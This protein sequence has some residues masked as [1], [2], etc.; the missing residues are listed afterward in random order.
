MTLSNVDYPS[1]FPCVQ[2]DSFSLT[3]GFGIMRSVEGRSAIPK[4]QR[5]E[6]DLPV[7]GDLSFNVP[8]NQLFAWMHWMNDNGFRWFNIEMAHPF[9]PAGT[10]VAKTPVRLIS[11]QMRL[12]YVQF[13]QVLVTVLVEL[14]PI[15]M[16]ESDFA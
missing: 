9:L 4:Q 6:N 7:Q 8:T 10:L 13:D 11:T 2:R 14:S 16:A 15:V 5:R 3:T 1:S 12:N